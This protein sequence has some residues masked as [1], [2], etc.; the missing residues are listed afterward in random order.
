MWGTCRRGKL[1]GQRYSSVGTS[2][3]AV[4]ILSSNPVTR[5]RPVSQD[6]WQDGEA[7]WFEVRTVRGQQ[8]AA[9]G[10]WGGASAVDSAALKPASL[11]GGA[12][13]LNTTT[14]RD[15]SGYRYWVTGLCG[16]SLPDPSGDDVRAV[17]G[18]VWQ[19]AHIFEKTRGMR[20]NWVKE[21]TNAPLGK[22]WHDPC[23]SAW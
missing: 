11:R 1:E 17:T 5:P 14:P 8:S 16:D 19:H 21:T 6:E 9:S 13:Y 10:K 15:Q 22:W 4:I 23:R 7:S 2:V 12:R 20:G 3:D 18:K